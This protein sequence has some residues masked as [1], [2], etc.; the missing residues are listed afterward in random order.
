MGPPAQRREEGTDLAVVVGAYH[1]PTAQHQL[2]QL[3]EALALT[4]KSCKARETSHLLLRT[5]VFVEFH[6]NAFR[7]LGFTEGS[8]INL[9]LNGA[10][11][12]VDVVEAKV[13]ERA[14]SPSVEIAPLLIKYV[15]PRASGLV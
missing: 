3:R 13:S 5:F 10:L 11:V 15:R 8:P 6:L 4:H 12:A 1:M 9:R 14:I 2:L 7:V